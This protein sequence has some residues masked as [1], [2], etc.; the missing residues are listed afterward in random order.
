[1]AIQ[2]SDRPIGLSA[3]VTRARKML[4][5]PALSIAAVN[6]IHKKLKELSDNSTKDQVAAAITYIQPVK[7]NQITDPK[8]KAII[9]EFVINPLLV[10]IGREA[11]PVQEN[12]ETA[13]EQVR[14]IKDQHKTEEKSIQNLRDFYPKEKGPGGINTRTRIYNAIDNIILKLATLQQPLG[15]RPDYGSGQGT[16]GDMTERLKKVRRDLMDNEAAMIKMIPPMQDY[17]EQCPP[18]S[19][20]A[21]VIEDYDEGPQP[22][23]EGPKVIVIEDYDDA[24]QQGCGCCPTCGQEIPQQ[25]TREAHCMDHKFKTIRDLLSKKNLTEAQIKTIRHALDEIFKKYRALEKEIDD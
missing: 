3:V 5:V 15:V 6:V 16:S 17:D 1:M 23:A 8:T 25:M 7:K 10:S 24:G 14:N 4:S 9:Q 20:E 2:T 11:Q 12:K 21:P 18:A 22:Q 13:I 19:P